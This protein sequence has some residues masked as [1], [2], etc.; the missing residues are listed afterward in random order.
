LTDYFD[1]VVLSEDAGANKPSPLFFDYSFQLTKAD[2]KTTAMIGDN[3]QTDIIG[4]KHAGLDT[5][6][7]NR[8]PDYPAPETVTYEIT[9]LRQL[10]DIL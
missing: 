8:F 7:F 3:F 5:I 9:A 4:A 1:T 10:K 2:V 6:F